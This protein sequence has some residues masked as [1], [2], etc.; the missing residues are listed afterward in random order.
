[1]WCEGDELE[2]EKKEDKMTPNMWVVFEVEILGRWGIN[3]LDVDL[4][5]KS[6]EG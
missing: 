5:L 1:M 3:A 4:H 6:K 2:I